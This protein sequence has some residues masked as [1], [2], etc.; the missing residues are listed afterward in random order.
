MP[1]GLKLNTIVNDNSTEAMKVLATAGAG[2]A[3]AGVAAY[4]ILD[5]YR[6]EYNKTNRIFVQKVRNIQK[7]C[8]GD[9][10]DEV[11]KLAFG[12]AFNQETLNKL[13]KEKDTILTKKVIPKVK[14]LQRTPKKYKNEQYKN[15]YFKRLQKAQTELSY[16]ITDEK[17]KEDDPFGVALMSDLSNKITVMQHVDGTQRELELLDKTIQYAQKLADNNLAT[18]S[19]KFNDRSGRLQSCVD[20]LKKA[21]TTLS[22][23]I[24]TRNAVQRFNATSV[25]ITN[26]ADSL[27][28]IGAYLQTPSKHHNLIKNSFTDYLKNGYIEKNFLI[29][30][31]VLNNIKPQTL[32]PTHPLTHVLTQTA[33]RLHKAVHPSE[34]SEDKITSV[35]YE[36]PS[37][38]TLQKYYDT[39]KKYGEIPSI[40]YTETKPH[41]NYNNDVMM[42]QKMTEN[43][44]KGAKNIQL[45][46][47]IY[48][49]IHLL[50]DANVIFHRL[51]I[52]AGYYGTLTAS[53]KGIM[54]T[55]YQTLAAIHKEIEEQY[56]KLE[57]LF[58]H[59]DQLKGYS[60]VEYKNKYKN[61]SEEVGRVREFYVNYKKNYSAVIE[62]TQEIKYNTQKARQNKLDLDINLENAKV[63]YDLKNIDNDEGNKNNFLLDTGRILQ[64]YSK[65]DLKLADKRVLA[66]INN[67]WCKLVDN[68]YK[69]SKDKKSKDDLKKLYE[70][71]IPVLGINKK[72][73]NKDE[74]TNADIKNILLDVDLSWT[75]VHAFL[76]PQNTKDLKGIVSESTRLLVR[77]F[78][79]TTNKY[80]N[81]HK[82]IEVSSPRIEEDKKIIADLTKK[83]NISQNLL[84]SVS[85]DLKNTQESLQKSQL[86]VDNIEKNLEKAN[87][88][89]NESK[90]TVTDL[91]E[92]HTKNVALLISNLDKIKNI[93]SKQD[94][95]FISLQNK[96]NDIKDAK[97]KKE[98]N[99]ELE[100]Y[101]DSREQRY[102]TAKT[103]A[104]SSI[105][106]LKK[107][108]SDFSSEI[109][110]LEKAIDSTQKAV[111]NAK[112]EI[113]FLKKELEK[114]IQEIE[115]QREVLALKAQEIKSDNKILTENKTRYAIKQENDKYTEGLVK[116]SGLLK[117]TIDERSK[118]KRLPVKGRLKRKLGQLE[119]LQQ[120]VKTLENKHPSIRNA[121]PLADILDVANEIVMTN[122]KNE[123]NNTVRNRTRD[124]YSTRLGETFKSSLAERKKIVRSDKVSGLQLDESEMKINDLTQK[125]CKYEKKAAKMM[126]EMRIKTLLKEQE[127]NS[128]DI[129]MTNKDLNKKVKSSNNPS[130]YNTA[131][132]VLGN[133]RAKNNN[134]LIHT[135][136]QN[137][138]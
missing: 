98:L 90:Q 51:G 92:L 64:K 65:V 116:I 118:K 134:N 63:K 114:K 137:L 45:L 49:F 132:T 107:S 20:E 136:T 103:L 91:R 88:N 117:D 102:N 73:K 24:D 129:G 99:I 109:A 55:S 37:Q 110:L 13:S 83:N 57:P 106:T 61:I 1:F 67:T 32:T 6:A 27:L 70:W 41:N 96:I 33:D 111:N 80:Y 71:A 133:R 74:Y 28:K 22:A 79:I 21:K 75:N 19:G 108:K 4:L 56:K 124:I 93:F 15:S 31:N 34:H 119:K 3:V 36:M 72:Y 130:L 43:H 42:L 48:S 122:S 9:L 17:R 29:K 46:S 120:F 35:K 25:E 95:K 78:F 123:I 104:E 47:N 135:T 87:K 58:K 40:L 16:L 86:R 50:L 5:R 76:R 26:F 44:Q 81:I 84:D 7:E 101:S 112:D 23:M 18:S 10:T 121:I 68:I 53:D 77:S 59:I 66:D 11:E 60:D 12:E 69:K 2:V 89:L 39:N 97:L 30:Q 105:E 8:Y 131:N 62:C 100:N 126:E 38:S 115:K 52:H 113:D 54:K 94:E 128:N 14:G 125:L 138:L 82:A 85:K 127:N